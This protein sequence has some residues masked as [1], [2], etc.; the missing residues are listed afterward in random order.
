MSSRAMPMMT[1]TRFNK[2]N[3]KPSISFL[4]SSCLIKKSYLRFSFFSE[5]LRS[6]G[7]FGFVFWG[8]SDILLCNRSLITCKNRKKLQHTRKK[9]NRFRSQPFARFEKESL[10]FHHYPLRIVSPFCIHDAHQINPFHQIRYIDL[11]RP[12]HSLHQLPKRIVHHHF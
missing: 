8:V 5:T 11:I 6:L 3:L 4:D 9:A 7:F 12:P 1:S 10:F 2:F